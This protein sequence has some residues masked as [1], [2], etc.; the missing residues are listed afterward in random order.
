LRALLPLLRHLPVDLR[1]HIPLV[2]N[3][4]VCL[5]Q[6]KLLLLARNETNAFPLLAL[7]ILHNWDLHHTQQKHLGHN[8]VYK[9]EGPK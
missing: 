5:W 7:E 3:L 2:Q 6:Q 8:L 4:L 1:H 9:R